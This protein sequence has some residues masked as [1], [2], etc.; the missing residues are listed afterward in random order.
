MGCTLAEPC[1]QDECEGAESR[2]EL[3]SRLTDFGDP[4][5]ALL[6]ERATARGTLAGD[7]RTVVDE[8]GQRLGCDSTTEASFVVLSNE[9]FTPKLI[10]SRCADDAVAASQFFLALPAVDA[11]GGT[12]AQLVHMVAWDPSAKLYRRYSTRAGAGGEMSVNVEPKFC[13]GCHGGPEKLGVW[14]PLM[15]ELTNPWSGWNAEPGFRSQLFDEYLAPAVAA[16][17]VYRAVTDP[18]RLRS[19]ADLEPIVRAGIDRVTSARVQQREATADLETALALLRPLFCDESV[20]FVS[21]LHG[22]GE[23]R[24]AAFIDPALPRLFGEAGVTGPW[25]WLDQT[26]VFLPP[27]TASEPALTLMPVRGETT[28]RAELAL[29]T[30]GVLS[31]AQVLAV[32]SIDWSRPVASHERC[33][34]FREGSERA[35]AAGSHVATSNAELI[36]QLY[37]G[38]MNGI[39]TLAPTELGALVDEQLRA[40]TRPGARA[41]HAMRRRDLACTIAAAFPITPIYPDLDCP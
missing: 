27:A 26:T 23:I 18:V 25:P 35:R 36:R 32:R 37:A 8:V 1:V 3:L 7:Y 31:A 30:R 6:R 34:L 13:L 41:A 16:S 10:L 17:P 28:I 15:N 40:A 22:G 19:A 4:I 5:A 2:E 11:A 14:T 21:E 12:D 33:T 39:G 38:I 24:S 29:V 20:N 9:A